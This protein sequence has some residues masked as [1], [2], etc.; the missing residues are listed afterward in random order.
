MAKVNLIGI[1]DK[2]LNSPKRTLSGGGST[3]ALC[4][5]NTLQTKLKYI[6]F[7][8]GIIV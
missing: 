2:N 7:K 1:P 4:P 6:C 8:Y 3:Q 5:F